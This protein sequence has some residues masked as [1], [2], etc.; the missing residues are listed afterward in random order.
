MRIMRG[1]GSIGLNL[2]ILAVFTVGGGEMGL[3][4]VGILSLNCGLKGG[5]RKVGFGCLSGG[6]DVRTG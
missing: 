3:L 2:F 6:G 4:N 5:S 1:G